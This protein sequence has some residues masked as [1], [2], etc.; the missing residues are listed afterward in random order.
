VVDESQ[1]KRLYVGGLAK[2]GDQDQN[3]Q[4]MMGIFTGFNP[5]AYSY[6]RLRNS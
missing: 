2:M 4:E 3:N 6:S 1:G 5:Y